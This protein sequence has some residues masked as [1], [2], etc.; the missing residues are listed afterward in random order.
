MALTEAQEKERAELV[1]RMAR[2]GAQELKVDNAG[3]LFDARTEQPKIVLNLSSAETLSRSDREATITNLGALAAVTVT[4]PQDA[5]S[6]DRFAFSVMA[7]YELR[8]DPGAAGAIYVNGVKQADSAY[9]YSDRLGDSI[10][11]AADGNGD[12]VSSGIVGV[13]N[14]QG[15]MVTPELKALQ[16]WFTV[17]SSLAQGTL[18]TGQKN[19][20]VADASKFATD[21]IVKISDDSNSEYNVVA[22]VGS[23]ESSLTTAQAASAQKDVA[24]TDGTK[25]ASGDI[26]LIK[27]DNAQEYN[28]VDSVSD[29]TVTM[30]TNLSNTYEVAD[31][32]FVSTKIVVMTTNLS[33]SYT[34]AANAYVV[35]GDARVGVLPANSVLVDALVHV[36]QAFNGNGGSGNDNILVG[37]TADEDGVTKGIWVD[38]TGQVCVPGVL[39]KGQATLTNGNTAVAVVHKAGRAPALE[40][41]TVYPIETLNNATF[42]YA[43]DPTATDFDINVDGDPGQDVDFA[44]YVMGDLGARKGYSGTARTLNIYYKF[45]DGAAP[46]TGKALVIVRYYEVDAAP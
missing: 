15:L 33:N 11:L 5:I 9:V 4:L 30:T 45:A 34:V 12:W 35:G 32:A 24:V 22:S 17:D 38:D 25:F 2:S 26:V 44:W 27:D 41:I 39:S 21:Y 10:V 36:E 28:E 29:N 18:D 3:N 1:R 16:K 13:W 31:N 7:A 23:N 8:V 6:G 19:C 40:D 46:T 43:D 20:A 37:W 42:W 14:V